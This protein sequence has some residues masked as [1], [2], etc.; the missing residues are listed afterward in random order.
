M[1]SVM[2]SSSFTAGVMSPT[3]DRPSLLTPDCGFFPASAR[4]GALSIRVGTL[5]PL[6]RE[7][8]DRVDHGTYGRVLLAIPD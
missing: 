5:L 3:S 6:E 8:H 2:L 4:D 1:I 7:A